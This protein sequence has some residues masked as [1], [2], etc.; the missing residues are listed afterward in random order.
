MRAFTI[1]LLMLCCV[2]GLSAQSFTINVDPPSRTTIG[3]TTTWTITVQPYDGFSAPI[4]FSARGLDDLGVAAT[5]APEVLRAPYDGSVT[6]TIVTG[7][8]KDGITRRIEIEAYNGL[9]SA[10]DTVEIKLPG[11][12]PWRTFTTENSGLPSPTIGRRLVVDS[13]GNGWFTGAQGDVRFDGTTW[14]TISEVGEITKLFMPLAADTGGVWFTTM[15]AD[16]SGGGLA[17]YDGNGWKLYDRTTGYADSIVGG[18]MALGYPAGATTPGGLWARS[19][20]GLLHYDGTRMRSIP[21]PLRA[22]R[23]MAVG[24]TGRS[25]LTGVLDTP[26]YYEI[27]AF[28]GSTWN[29]LTLSETGLPTESPSLFLPTAVDSADRLWIT[30]G[31]PNSLYILDPTTRRATEFTDDDGSGTVRQGVN[32]IGWDATGDLWI[33]HGTSQDLEFRAV[34]DGVHRW[35]GSRWWHYTKENSGLIDNNVY[36]IQIDRKNNR[37]WIL[38]RGGLSILDGNAPPESA[39]AADV[40]EQASLSTTDGRLTALYPNPASGIATIGLMLRAPSRV[41][42]AVMDLLGGIVFEVPERMLE[43]G[44]QRIGLD[45]SKAP[46]GA[47]MVR[48][49]VNDRVESAP[50]TIVR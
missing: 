30:Y 19:T 3:T 7:G 44:A 8:A 11:R 9:I 43:T 23:S 5:F 17:Y 18:A 42:I 38:S 31:D 14:T 12:S 29:E 50:I 10:R 33:G 6:V 37:I 35:D 26:P 20:N 2:A 41:S 22:W 47:Y 21:L 34:P 39:L 1:P 36:D 32:C 16:A 40:R 4:F 15:L 24:R 25:W 28:D 48:A 49:L 46:A 13:S 45:L 27:L